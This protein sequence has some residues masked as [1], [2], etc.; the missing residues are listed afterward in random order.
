MNDT[1]QH[2]AFIGTGIMG[3]PMA[4]HLIEDLGGEIYF[5]TK[6]E[7]LVRDS[8]GASRVSAV[9]CSRE[10]GS[11]AKYVGKKAVVLATGDFSANRDMMYAYAPSYAPYISDDVYDGETNYD[12]GCQYRGLSIGVGQRMGLWV[13]AAWL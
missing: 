12:M 13:G 5:K 2:V 8:D 3:A 1:K 6:S 4:R 7:Q 10:D 9:V 11:F